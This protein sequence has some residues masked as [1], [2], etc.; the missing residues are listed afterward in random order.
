MKLASEN[1]FCFLKLQPPVSKSTAKI[2]VAIVGSFKLSHSKAIVY[3]LM[4]TIQ[5]D[6]WVVQITLVIK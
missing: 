6:S 4:H 1:T 2:A 5:L 3:F